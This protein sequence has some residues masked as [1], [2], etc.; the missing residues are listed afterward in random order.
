MQ[1]QPHS[2]TENPLRPSMLPYPVID[3]DG[4]VLA[5]GGCYSNLEATKA[6]LREASRLHIPPE[7]IVCTGD[8]VAYCAD[9]LETVRLIRDSGIHVIMGNCEESL[10]F[11]AEDCG[12]GFNAG[13][14]CDRLSAAWYAHANAQL[15][16]PSRA[17]MRDLPR[18]IDIRMAGIRLAVVHGAADQINRFL[19]ASDGDA[20]FARQLDI[21]GY[22]GVI[23][24]HCGL[25]F[26][27]QVGGR[28]WH[29][30]GAIGMPANDG[31][32]RT[33]YSLLQPIEGGLAIRHRPLTFD[34]RSTSAKMRS[35]GLPEGYAEALLTGLWPSCDVLPAVELAQRARPLAEESIRWTP[36]AQPATPVATRPALAKFTD[37]D[38]TA[39]GAP[40]AVVPLRRLKTLWFN[41]GT[42]CNLACTN[43]YI[44]SSPRNDRLAYLSRTEA[45]RFL[46]EA[47]AA[48]PELE[49][50]GFTGGEPFM[51]PDLL[52]MLEDALRSGFR[53]L[54][55]T[56]AM[57]PMQRV[58]APLLDLHRR[59][60][61]Q[62]ALRVSL[63]HYQAERHER[64]RGARTWQPTV[65][66]LRWLAANGFDISVAGRM[67]WAESEAELRL[68]YGSLYAQLGIALDAHDASRT[69]LFPE[70]D[71][72]ADVPEITQACW[73]ILGKTPDSVMCASSR[74]VVQR[75]GA[76]RASVVACT[77]LPYDE[78][79]EL[80]STLGE[81][82]QAVSLNHRHCAKFCVLGGASCSS[83][84]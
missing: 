46:T 5:F 39:S 60:P 82:A 41:T 14:A 50:I 17:W 8:V 25:P 24:G 38:I 9:A 84:A 29:N 2:H 73:S 69:V 19:F 33:W 40:R 23:A 10:G 65:D 18:R 30:A 76:E 3:M 55:L 63:D 4:P 70:M 44:E 13:S 45:R 53:V 32:T 58:K 12:C 78:R 57:K 51:N 11:E 75:N 6:V 72:H 52:P 66:G 54:V 49:E 16:V 62:L 67:L 48:H 80:G 71:D 68:G 43:C 83:P 7:R 61:G 22:D 21:L 77:L 1:R 15:D 42:L 81:A 47:A 37:P 79:F 59:F 27:R 26:T 74:M 35:A 31:T 56:N 36:D 64:I 20:D 34:H 28:L